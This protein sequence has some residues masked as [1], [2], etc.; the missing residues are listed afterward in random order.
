LLTYN[1]FGD[2][3]CGD[4][5]RPVKRRKKFL[6]LYLY[7]RELVFSNEAEGAFKVIVN[8]LPGGAGG[9]SLFGAA[10]RFIVFP[11]ADIA[12]IFHRGFLLGLVGVLFFVA[13]L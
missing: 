12:Y 6:S 8:F 4:G 9:D 13:L 7:F 1:L 11:S 2:R 5:R 3:P 10:Q